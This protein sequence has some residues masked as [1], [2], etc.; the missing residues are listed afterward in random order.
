MVGREE[1]MS[2]N[3]KQ[4]YGND[5]VRDSKRKILLLTDHFS[6]ALSGHTVRLLQLTT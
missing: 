5:S 4:R 3:T 2:R 1:E 6:S